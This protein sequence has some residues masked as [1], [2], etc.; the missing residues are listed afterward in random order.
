MITY[1]DIA[2][3]YKDKAGAIDYSPQK[4]P[5]QKVAEAFFYGCGRE[6]DLRYALEIKK[7]MVRQTLTQLAAFRYFT[8][9]EAFDL[10][11]SGFL[12]QTQAD[13]RVIIPSQKWHLYVSYLAYQEVNAYLD[14]SSK[15]KKVAGECFA[16]EP[17]FLARQVRQKEYA[18][19]MKKAAGFE[20]DASW[21]DVEAVI[22]DRRRK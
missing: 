19:W 4:D 17:F 6:D 7:R 22:A 8:E 14:I 21:E 16:E 9:E 20:A 5:C 3:F 15:I 18:A 12:P 1:D 13:Q 11:V 2:Y 10:V